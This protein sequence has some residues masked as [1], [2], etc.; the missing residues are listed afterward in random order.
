MLTPIIAGASPPRLGD[1]ST[2]SETVIEW[3]QSSLPTPIWNTPVYYLLE[4]SQINSDVQLN[5]TVSL[6]DLSELICTVSYCISQS[7]LTSV[8]LEGIPPETNITARVSAHSL[9]YRSNATQY[10]NITSRP[11]CTLV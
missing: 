7:D 5:I 4:Y 1:S 9:W 11:A 2:A 8:T 6:L 10:S 3:D